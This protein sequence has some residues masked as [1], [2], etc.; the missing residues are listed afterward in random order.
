MFAFL[1]KGINFVLV[2]TAVG[3]QSLIYFFKLVF[4]QGLSPF[5]H[6]SQKPV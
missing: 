1:D 3:E 2:F 4:S 6:F 5:E